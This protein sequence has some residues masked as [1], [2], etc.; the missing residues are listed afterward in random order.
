MQWNPEISPVLNKS[1]L[2][3]MVKWKTLNREEYLLNT[4]KDYM[5]SNCYSLWKYPLIRTDG[6]IQGCCRN[7]TSSFEGNAFDKK[8]NVLVNNR[9]IA[10]ARNVLM[11]ISN[12]TE[13][14]P[15]KDCV[16]YQNI[17]RFDNFL[18]LHEIFRKEKL[19][20]RSARY[21]FHALKP[22]A[23]KITLPENIRR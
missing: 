14:I 19:W 3:K 9:K 1:L 7:Q 13:Y 18:T 17:K 16:L 23:S 5:R 6:S 10:D 22:M 11:G 2:R 21:L 12:E 8:I 4:K 20:Y 15:C